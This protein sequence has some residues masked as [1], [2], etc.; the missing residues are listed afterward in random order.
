[1][2]RIRAIF[3]RTAQPTAANNVPVRPDAAENVLGLTH[4]TEPPL[5][6]R[7]GTV[8]TS[9]R[10]RRLVR[11]H[12]SVG[13][14]F[15]RKSPQRKIAWL[16]RAANELR[17]GNHPHLSH[18]AVGHRRL[19]KK[20]ALC[21][22]LEIAVEFRRTEA[23]A[24]C[25]QLMQTYEAVDI[26]FPLFG[27]PFTRARLADWARDGL[28]N[29][30]IVPEAGILSNRAVEGMTKTMQKSNP[31]NVHNPAVMIA[32]AEQLTVISNRVPLAERISDRRALAEIRAYLQ[33][34]TSRTPATRGLDLVLERVDNVT[35]FD[36]SP[37]DTLFIVWNYMR[38]I[39][40]EQLK[41]QLKESMTTKLREIGRE[42][43]CAVGIIE[44]VIDIPTA[45]DWSITQRLSL[46]HLR[47]ELQTMAGTVCEEFDA[48]N[49]E[50]VAMLKT[51]AA[52]EQEAVIDAEMTVAKRDRFFATSDIDLGMMRGIHRPLV[53]TQAEA[54]FPADLAL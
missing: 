54:I 14:S 13:S 20:E 5:P 36:K 38:A 15:E 24:L 46:D 7:Q 10:L 41:T 51:N 45:I 4:P 12:L 34:T 1:M 35:N 19:S 40:D 47:F 44:R 28:L 42:G 52:P 23:P 9:V 11:P 26:K 33:T 48:E 30:G 27:V 50:Y 22:A 6:R 31:Q 17:D 18:I 53:R 21:F 49:A 37:R 29:N 2:D 16:L 3:G 32:L 39:T 25:T 43:P 8:P